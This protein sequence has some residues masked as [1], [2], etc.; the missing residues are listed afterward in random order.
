MAFGSEAVIRQRRRFLHRAIN[1]AHIALNK[2][3]TTV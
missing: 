1:S 2:N 3:R